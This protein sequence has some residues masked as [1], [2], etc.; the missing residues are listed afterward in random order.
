MFKKE[1]IL[2]TILGGF[3]VAN[4]LIAEMIGSKIFSLEKTLGFSPL[5]LSILGQEHLSLNLS[6]GTILW[7][8]VFVLTDIINEYYGK[9]GVRLLTFLAAGLILYA[10]AMIFAAIQTT[11]ADFWL[12]LNQGI[13]PDINAAYSKVFGQG[14]N[15]IFA[16]FVTFCLSQW[17]DAWLFH[18]LRTKLGEQKLGLR[19]LLST[20]ISQA[21]D[22]FLIAFIA[23]YVLGNWTMSLLLALVCVSY[24]YKFIM[25]IITMPF[26]YL[27]HYGIEKYLG[28]ALAAELKLKAREENI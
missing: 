6:A 3:F 7:P 25:A 2:F 10:F 1:H 12:N 14:L 27:V 17:L 18:A 20:L 28:T 23:F 8:F 4:V 22:T 9:K 11:P 24:P 26:L 15:I 19:A 16:S 13:L 21:L 5:D